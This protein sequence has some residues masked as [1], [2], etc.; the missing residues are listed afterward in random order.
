[1]NEEIANDLKMQQDYEAEVKVYRA[2]EKLDEPIMVLHGL[3]YTHFQ[4]RVWDSK[5]IPKICSSSQTT[6][7]CKKSEKDKVEGEHDFI[8]IGPDYVV[9]IEVKNPSSNEITSA[10]AKV[11]LQ[12]ENAAKLIGAIAEK[13]KTAA[14]SS[15]NLFQIVAFPNLGRNDLPSVIEK[16]TKNFSTENISDENALGENAENRLVINK[17]HLKNFSLFWNDEV[18]RSSPWQ[19]V[20]G[21]I[22][23]IQCVLLRLFANANTGRAIDEKKVSLAEC[24]RDIDQ[25]LRDG[26][27]TFRTQKRPPNPKVLRTSELPLV[28]GINIFQDCLGLKYITT[29]QWE[30]Y[31]SPSEHLIISGPCGSGKTLILLARIIRVA[32]TK[33]ESKI[34]FSVANEMKLTNYT[35]IF[36]NTPIDFRIIDA[37][38]DHHTKIPIILES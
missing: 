30:A 8:V 15:M 37:Q 27:I 4:F 6:P 2:L 18:K 23:K 17:D 26:E 20:C 28:E 19:R 24:V 34:V 13:T 10:V 9:V 36:R 11:D 29:E 7:S 22:D 25:K 16:S 14:Q 32:L 33:P 31:Q 3:K 21:D 12:F 5:H 35:E 38:V 1:M